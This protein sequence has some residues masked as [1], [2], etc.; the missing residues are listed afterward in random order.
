MVSILDS[1]LIVERNVE[2]ALVDD[3]V[4]PNVIL[5]RYTTIRG[6]LRKGSFEPREPITHT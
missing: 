2:A 3:G 5:A 1:Q 4:H 6:I